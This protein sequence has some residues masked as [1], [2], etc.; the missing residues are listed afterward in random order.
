MYALWHSPL[1]R[2]YLTLDDVDFTVLAATSVLDDLVAFCPPARACRNA[3]SRMTKA[4]IKM[5]LATT[6]FGSQANQRTGESPT[7]A[8]SEVPYSPVPRFEAAP[9]DPKNP[10]FA[11]ALPSDH[12]R[13]RP[14]FD[15]D[16]RSLFSEE[17]SAGRTFGQR[18][19]QL[20]QYQMAQGSRPYPSIASTA[21]LP[22]G[23][24]HAAD[25]TNTDQAT[26]LNNPFTG[27]EATNPT[28]GT[29]P[30]YQ[31]PVPQQSEGFSMLSPWSELEFL[32]TVSIP[33][34]V[35]GT[36]VATAPDA[37]GFD[38]GFGLGWDGSL[39]NFNWND[40]PASV[41]LFDGFFFGGSGTTG[42]DLF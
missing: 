24:V 29:T 26:V 9:F 33:D 19:G 18:Y 42:P 11:Y 38:T 7:V 16:L 8:V 12:R 6:G 15:P 37:L 13:K 28:M 4:T 27:S 3:F 31:Q 34:Q 25:N 20:Q 30:G 2:S 32:D 17:E 21:M 23:Q 5:C 39:P 40:G 41:D 22:I 1:V 14:E 10:N 35:D 36:G